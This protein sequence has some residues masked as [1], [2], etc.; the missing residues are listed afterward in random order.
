[1]LQPTKSLEEATDMFGIPL[2][3]LVVHFPVV[4]AVLLPISAIVALWVI[5]KGASPRKVWAVPFAVAAALAAS[6][7]VATET[8]EDQEDRVERVVARGAI[9]GHEEAAERFLVLSG[10]LVVIAAGGLARGTVGRAARYVSA[11]GALGLVAAAAQVGHSGGVLVYREGAASAY[12]ATAAGGNSPVSRV[13]S[14]S[15]GDGV[16]RF[17]RAKRGERDDR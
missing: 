7:W 13:D 14:P 11:A 6:A 9:H 4:L 8:G 17:A 12:T 3:P 10:V 15:A 5:R 2:H 1:M 16:E